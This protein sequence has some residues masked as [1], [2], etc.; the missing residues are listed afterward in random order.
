MGVLNYIGNVISGRLVHWNDENKR[1]IAELWER[2]N[3]FPEPIKSAFQDFIVT[4]SSLMD[5]LL[6]PNR[7]HQRLIKK[8]PLQITRPQYARIQAI[9]LECLVGMFLQLNPSVADS[10]KEALQILTGRDLDQS[11]TFQLTQSMKEPDVM[12]IGCAAWKEI[13]A[14]AEASQGTTP[15]DAYPFATVLG[16]FAAQ[17]FK[18][19]NCRLRALLPCRETKKP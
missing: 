12:D 2:S 16:S 10:F 5:I 3:E 14:V 19:I 7:G 13:V 8:D 1:L 18:G 11:S 17:S 9:T 4:C 6:G 15:L